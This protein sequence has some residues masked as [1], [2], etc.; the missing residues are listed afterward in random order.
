MLAKRFAKIGPPTRPLLPVY[1]NPEPDELY[2]KFFNTYA[3]ENYL[4]VDTK[5]LCGNDDDQLISTTDRHGV[6]YHCV[7]CNSCGL[8]R[9]KKY[10]RDEDIKDFYTFHYR[11]TC[12]ESILPAK[13]KWSVQAEQSRYRIELI[14]KHS[15]FKF[16]N[17][18]VLVDIGGAAGGFFDGYTEKCKCILF[19]YFEPYLEYARK[20][21][22]STIMG[23]LK[24][25]NL[26]NI[27]PDL[28][29]INHVVEHWNIFELE[30]DELIKACKK[31]KTLIYIEFPGVDSLKNGRRGGDLLGD[32]HIPHFYYFASYVFTN[33]MERKGFK[34]IF[35]DDETRA[36]YIYTGEKKKLINNYK[37]VWNDLLE[38]ETTRHVYTVKHFIRLFIPNFILS[39]KRK[40]IKSAIR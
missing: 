32:I 7:I 4:W 40:F 20:K 28:I 5:C 34:E 33:I 24:E 31:D 29:V 36:I 23:G 38:A 3:K 8:I 2:F 22:V 16:E 27:K 37:K 35:I 17:E 18:Q 21:G 1:R 39:L 10:L 12:K 19:D 6:E 14:K 9:P 13:D 11:D 30:V 15:N 25:L 26:A